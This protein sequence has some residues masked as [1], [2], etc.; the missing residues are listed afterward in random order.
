MDVYK[1]FITEYQMTDLEIVEH[2]HHSFL[3]WSPDSTQNRPINRTFGEHHLVEYA[4]AV[5]EMI[6][7]VL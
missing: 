4:H 5:H 2:R 3:F 1:A 7:L 6:E